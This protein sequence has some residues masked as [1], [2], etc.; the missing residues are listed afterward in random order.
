M[1]R[2]RYSETVG[3]I[4]AIVVMIAALLTGLASCAGHVAQFTGW[5]V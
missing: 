3:T 1:N 5:V 4:I 2:R